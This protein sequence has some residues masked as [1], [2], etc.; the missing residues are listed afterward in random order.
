MKVFVFGNEF[1][2]DDKKAKEIASSL[3][4]PGVEFVKCQYAEEL[5]DEFLAGNDLVILDV[6][7]GIK[8][9][10]VFDDISVFEQHKPSSLHD[11]DL[12]FFLKL[13][14][15]AGQLKGKVRIIGVPG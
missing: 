15:E 10:T 3:E 5:L 1:L 2:E 13:L 9:V 7:K 6:V 4:V 14:K 11:F 12:G 8:E